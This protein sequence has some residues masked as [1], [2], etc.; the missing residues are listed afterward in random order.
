MSKQSTLF[1]VLKDA[2]R[3][4]VVS[5]EDMFRSLAK[6]GTITAVY[7]PH[8]KSGTITAVYAPHVK[9]SKPSKAAADAVRYKAPTA[10]GD[11]IRREAARD[12]RREAIEECIKVA[13]E[14]SK[15]FRIRL[16]VESQEGATRVE[17]KLR[18]LLE[19]DSTEK[20]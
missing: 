9:G 19:K 2:P 17:H 18:A 1:D 12:A 3:G 15:Y 5:E 20:T 10:L 4:S 13:N 7:A 11:K 8:A 6:S 14:T 16:S